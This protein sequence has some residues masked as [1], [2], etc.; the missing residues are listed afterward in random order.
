[1]PLIWSLLQKSVW[2][3]WSTEKAMSG[4][5][6]EK[7]GEWFRGNTEAGC[8]SWFSF[9]LLP[10]FSQCRRVGCTANEGHG[11]PHRCSFKAV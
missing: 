10:P 3:T 5:L 8:I 4:R 2:F 1:M 6:K 7:N 9:F 11:M